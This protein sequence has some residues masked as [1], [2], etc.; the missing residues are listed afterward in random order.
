MG[1]F[2]ETNLQFKIDGKVTIQDKDTGETV[3]EKNNAIHP[4]LEQF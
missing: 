4:W 3:F 2:V 1:T